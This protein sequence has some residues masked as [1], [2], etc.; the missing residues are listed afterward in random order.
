M[1]YYCLLISLFIS[2]FCI[3]QSYNKIYGLIVDSMTLAPVPYAN[4]YNHQTEQGTISNDNGQFELG[5]S[6]YQDSI[7]VSY[8]GYNKHAIQLQ[9]G[10]DR[11]TVKL[12]EHTELLQEVVITPKENNHLFDL[13]T[14]CRKR[15][16]RGEKTAK[17]IYELR[18]FHDSTQIELI[19]GYYNVDLWGYDLKA[20]DLKAGRLALQPYQNRFFTSKESSRAISLLKLMDQDPYMPY[21]PLNFGYKKMKQHYFL[22]LDHKYQSSEKDSIYVI[23]YEPRREKN[24][25]FEGRIWVNKTDE[26]ILKITLNCA[27]AER[28]PFLPLFPSDSLKK[29]DLIITKTFSEENGKIFFQHVDFNYSIGYS[30]RIGKQNEFS[31]SI[32][33]KA[34][35]YAYNYSEPFF[36]PRFEFREVG[37]Y[38]KIQAYP[39][40]E[41]FWHNHNEYHLHGSK[42]RNDAFYFDS[43]SMTNQS[44]FDQNEQTKVGFFQYPY[45]H[46]SEDRIKFTHLIPDTSKADINTVN[47]YEQFNL[48]VKFF[49]DFNTYQDSTHILSSTIFDPY[50]SFYYLPIDKKTHCFVNIY[51][52]LCEVKRRAFIEKL[53]PHIH[54]QVMINRIYQAFLSEFRAFHFKFL[55][56]TGNGTNE[57]QIKKWNQIVVETLGI[58][59]VSIFQPFD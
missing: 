59:N 20:L 35:L 58:D 15:Q 16:K 9:E 57:K 18:T 37:D 47:E 32:N 51:F 11:Y 54:D 13:L 8:I 49:L 52:D 33:T 55:K 50:E 36:E 10:M 40:N 2:N 48:G 30:S 22:H 19:E 53:E 6:S 56:S 39:I 27:N 29:V 38:T 43:L 21:G 24:H 4:I 45:V 34:V 5:I 17:A 26:T 14:Q 25:Y 31:Y 44:F 3:G 12:D 42:T 7:T 1:K 23:S 28:H 46:W 41:F